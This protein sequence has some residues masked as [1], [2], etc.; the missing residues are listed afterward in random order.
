MNRLLSS[1]KGKFSHPNPAVL[2]NKLRTPQLFEY[3]DEALVECKQVIYKNFDHFSVE[4]L[5]YELINE[6]FPRS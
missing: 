6:I 4:V 3:Y 5:C 2:T 1:T